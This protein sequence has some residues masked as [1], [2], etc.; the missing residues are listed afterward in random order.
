MPDA[1]N[2]QSADYALSS[3]GQDAGAPVAGKT[4]CRL[5]ILISGRGSNMRTLV[6]ACRTQGW[7]AEIVGVIANKPDAAGLSWA[8]EQGLETLALPHRDYASREAFDAA[9]AQAVDTFEPDYIILAGFM[10][11]LTPGFVQRYAGRLVNIHPSLLPA[12][13]GLHTHAQALAN[14]VQAHGCTVHFVTPVLD[15]GPIIAQSV[16]PV[17]ADDTPDTLAD[18]VL[19]TEHH[20][21]PQAVR[22][23]AEGRVSQAADGR[24]TVAGVAS[25]LYI[26]QAEA[27]H[28]G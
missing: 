23:L 25:R 27:N 5:L 10:R 2:R 11:V 20:I 3:A 6:E 18:R 1:I 7:P 4:P 17:L 28:H 15:H 12:F 13:P 8:R 14:G 19:E 26:W 24:V 16:V 22:W 21:F 9:L